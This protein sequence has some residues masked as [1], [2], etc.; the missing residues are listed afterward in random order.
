MTA[1]N[2][3]A[4]RP[5]ATRAIPEDAAGISAPAAYCHTGVERT[6]SDIATHVRAAEH[7]PSRPHW[8]TA[9]CP[10]WCG[11]IHQDSD[12]YPDRAH[13]LA[14]LEPLELSLYDDDHA[15]N[16]STPGVLEVSV[17]QHYRQAEPTIGLVMP[18]HESGH[19]RVTG[20]YDLDLTVAEARALRDQ[21]TEILTLVGSAS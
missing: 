12:Y 19:S 18:E 8:Q 3:D 7:T 13:Y 2:R 1:R 20:E 5:T 17:L 9:P 15:G 11:E 10:S 6:L 21:L 14:P 4:T 16:G